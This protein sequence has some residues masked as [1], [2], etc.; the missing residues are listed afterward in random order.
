M[1][2]LFYDSTLTLVYDPVSANRTAT[3]AALF[4]LGF[5]TIETVQTLEAFV[6]AMRR[7][8]PDLA[9]C[10]AQ[11]S[12]EALCAAIQSIR[13]DTAGFNP[14]IA[15]IV[16]AWE[17]GAGLVNRVVNSG[18]DDLLLRP[19]STT[20]L[21]QRIDTLVE[22]RKGFVVTTD[23]IGPDR[24]RDAARPSNAQLF[25]P[26]NSLRMKAF[27]RVSSED[28]ALRMDAELREACRTLN[29]EKLKRDA[30]QIAILWKLMQDESPGTEVYREQLRSVVRVA[31]GVRRRAADTEFGKSTEWCS[32]ILAGVE[33]LE[34]GVDRNA[35]MHLLGHASI[36]LCRLLQPHRAADDILAEVESTA[37]MILARNAAV[38]SPAM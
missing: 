27:D 19:F 10:E 14:F 2:R 16:T 8:P 6:E 30:F 20:L 28:A 35:S 12:D 7:R 32:S 36:S 1:A 38:S 5:R 11:G 29:T 34:R 9:L 22:R 25:H 13:Q 31:N 37:A 24:R 21:G 15:I 33:G 4:T 3:R 26:P 18:A 23:Y 17:K